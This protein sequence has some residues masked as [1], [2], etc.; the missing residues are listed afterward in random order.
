MQSNVR[1][2]LSIRTLGMSI[3]TCIDRGPVIRW[4]RRK[5]VIV[6]V[7]YREYDL[8][9]QIFS[10]KQRIKGMGDTLPIITDALLIIYMS[11]NL[12][13]R[14]ERC[15]THIIGKQLGQW[16]PGGFQTPILMVDQRN[17]TLLNR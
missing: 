9:F 4:T 13:F 7:I 12:G 1:E 3:D 15:V 14:V 11:V 17:N 16:Y 8:L 2:S 10:F 6:T 5:V